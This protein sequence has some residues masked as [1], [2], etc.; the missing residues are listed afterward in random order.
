MSI[1]NQL[2][3]PFRRDKKQPE[4][5]PPISILIISDDMST[6]QDVARMLG[7]NGYQVTTSPDIDDGVACLERGTCDLIIGD[8]KVPE[9]DARQFVRMAHIRRG[10]KSLPPFVL[11]WDE[12]NDELVANELAVSDVVRKPI[13]LAALLKVVGDLTKRSLTVDP[14]KQ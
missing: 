8:F 6:A 1:L 12:P 10:Q 14:P 3:R 9:E 7:E 5:A 13:D 2:F 4:A 11:L